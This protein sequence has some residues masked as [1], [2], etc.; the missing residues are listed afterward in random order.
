MER[1]SHLNQPLQEHLL[2]LL[3]LQ[4]DALPC[5]VCCK[6]LPCL[7]E[8]QAFS[9]CTLDPIKPHPLALKPHANIVWTDG[10]AGHHESRRPSRTNHRTTA[11]S[12]PCWLVLHGV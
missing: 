9:R 5:L 2:R 1:G 12:H 10:R 11:N 8:S 4:P 6:E 3:R 7:I